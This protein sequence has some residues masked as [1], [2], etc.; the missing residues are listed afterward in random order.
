M[1]K[2]VPN[3]KAPKG[4]FEGFMDRLKDRMEEKSSIIPED[5]G[6]SV[7]EGYFEDLPERLNQRL[8]EPKGRI[9][10]FKPWMYAAAAGIA[11]LALIPWNSGTADEDQ[12]DLA[13]SEL[14]DYWEKADLEFAAFE[15][16]EYENIN[17]EALTVD[18]PEVKSEVLLDYLDLQLEP[19]DQE[20]L[21]EEDLILDYDEEL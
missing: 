14:E 11:L 18:S 3:F 2:K 21:L 10:Q 8:H 9:V 15:I 4:Y 13:L 12:F 1:K 5:D 7:P 16:A 19:Q 6:F 20:N 17:L